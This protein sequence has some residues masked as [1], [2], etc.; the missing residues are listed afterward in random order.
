M[1]PNTIIE[2]HFYLLATIQS[3]ISSSA[4]TAILFLCSIELPNSKAIFDN[5]CSKPVTDY[6]SYMLKAALV[7]LLKKFLFVLQSYLIVFLYEQWS[8]SLCVAQA[9]QG[10]SI[11]DTK[12]DERW[13]LFARSMQRAP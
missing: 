8:E 9:M 3:L 1:L 2:A 11:R 13:M 4:C 6:A 7:D 12:H 5:L 10:T